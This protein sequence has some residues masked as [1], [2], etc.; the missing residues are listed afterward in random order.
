MTS[1]AGLFLGFYLFPRSLVYAQFTQL[2]EVRLDAPIVFPVP[3]P[4]RC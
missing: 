4:P 1:Y 2:Y 3:I